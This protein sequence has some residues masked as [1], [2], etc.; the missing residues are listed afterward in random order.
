MIRRIGGHHALATPDPEA[1]AFDV[2]SFKPSLQK[3]ECGGF[4]LQG[5]THHFMPYVHNYIT[6]AKIAIILVFYKFGWAYV[7]K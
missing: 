2:A 7:L 3:K 5:C 6:I 1:H 4:R